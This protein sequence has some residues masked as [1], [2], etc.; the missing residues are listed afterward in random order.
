M[1]TRTAIVIVALVFA[2]AAALH[3][4]FG[5]ASVSTSSLHTGSPPRRIVSMAPSVTETLF[6]LGLG[7]R[8]VGVTRYCDYPPEAASKAKIGGFL[9]PNYEAIVKL[10]PDL[11]VLLVIHSE[12]RERLAQLAISTLSVD[13]RTVEGIFDSF[14]QIGDRCGAAPAAGRLV[15]KCQRRMTAVRDKTAGLDRPRVLISSA[16][17][18]G[19]GRVE[20]VYA[21]GHGQWYD[22]L[23]DLAGGE[24]AYPD[25]GIAFPEIGPEGLVRLDPDVIV[26][27]APEL[28]DRQYTVQDLVDEWKTIPGLRAV[29]DGRVYVLH[30]DYVAI[31]GPRFVRVLEDLAHVLHPNVDWSA[32]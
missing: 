4:L 17:A 13:H 16:R 1:R 31:P 8:V 9:D 25:D 27:M 29:E 7:D 23:I 6:A 20:T 14:H 30:G 19:T 10:D 28:D 32:P 11:V 21:A 2:G 12:A 3:L 18:L 26:E 5:G 15:A 24:N 22:E